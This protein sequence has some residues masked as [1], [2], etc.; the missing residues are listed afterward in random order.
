MSK[1]KKQPKYMAQVMLY[2]EC[3]SEVVTYLPCKSQAH[4][5]KKLRKGLVDEVAHFDSFSVDAAAIMGSQIQL[6]TVH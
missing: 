2:L 6:I 1:K 5:E 3:G 4:L